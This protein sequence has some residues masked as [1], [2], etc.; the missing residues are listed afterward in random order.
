MT[1][2]NQ[3]DVIDVRDVIARVEE[4]RSAIEAYAEKMIDWQE[5]ADNTEELEQLE[6]LL[7]ELAG[8]GGDEKWEGQW[9]PVTL[10][11]DSHFEDYARELVEEIGD[12]PKGLPI[13]IEV[14][15]EATARNVRMDY[16]SVE[17]DGVTYWYR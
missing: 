14:D 5:N 4:L 2:D 17:F 6:S 3:A 9:Y 12:L 7:S 1:I 15:W 11:R 8:N 10:I 13:Y 16:S